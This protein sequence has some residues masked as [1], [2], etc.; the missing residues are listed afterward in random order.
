MKRVN[1]TRCPWRRL[2]RALAAC[3]SDDGLEEGED[4][5]TKLTVYHITTTRFHAALSGDPRRILRG[6]GLGR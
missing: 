5:L 3:G 2:M 1:E 4:G 6:R